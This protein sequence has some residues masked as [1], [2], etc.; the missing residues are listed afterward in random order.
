MSP[1]V[2]EDLLQ[3]TKVVQRTVVIPKKTILLLLVLIFLT[4]SIGLIKLRLQSTKVTTQVPS[5]SEGLS[6]A[7][8]TGTFVD[9]VTGTVVFLKDDQLFEYLLP[10]RTL[11]Q[12]VGVR[13]EKEVDQFTPIQPTWSPDGSL[14]AVMD[15]SSHVTL[16]EYQTG[17]LRGSL[18]LREKLSNGK[19][20]VL[21]IDPSSEVLAVGITGSEEVAMQT[22]EFFALATGKSLGVYPRCETHG[23][24]LRSL[25]FLTKCALGEVESVVLIQFHPASSSM[26]PL[27]K[28]SATVRYTLIDQYEPEKAIAIR[29]TQETRD[30]VTISVSG[31]VQEV[32]PK[33][34]PKNLDVAQFVD[35]YSALAARIE[36]ETGLMGVKNISVA[37]TNDWM[38]FETDAG[39]YVAPVSLKE[40]PYFIGL[41]TLPSIRPY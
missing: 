2:S 3:D 1:S 29:T 34:Y 28:E 7:V 40:K 33:D 30:L 9:T 12:L 17:K 32:P 31:K 26:V 15:D 35:I 14:L 18:L 8:P 25:G 21:S 24:W 11:R 16:T 27:T 5:L 20:G 4:V 37:S 23:V 10:T 39:L 6:V 41:G 38:V 13:D 22:L 19:K 36:K